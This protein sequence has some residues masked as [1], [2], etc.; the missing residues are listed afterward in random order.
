MKH[1]FYQDIEQTVLEAVQECF[2]QVS[3]RSPLLEIP[4]DDSLGDLSSSIALKLASAQ[5]SSPLSIAETIKEALLKKAREDKTLCIAKIVIVKPGFLNIY[6]TEQCLKETAFDLVQQ[7][8]YL[9]TITGHSERILLEYVSANPTGPLSIAHGRQAIIGDVLARVFALCEVPVKR[10]YYINDEGRQIDLLVQSFGERVKQA[11][12]ESYAIPEDGYQGEYL[13]PIA[14]RYV[15]EQSTQD[16]EIYCL[17]AMLG[18]IKDELSV[19]GVGFD[20]WTSQKKLRT[21]GLIAE[22]ISVLRSQG[23]IE[24]KEDATWFKSTLFGDDKDRVLI[25]KDGSYTYFA[26][27]IA[28][29]YM[30]IKQGYT[31]LINLW[32]PDHHGYI[33][34]MKASL[35]AL[36]FSPAALDILIIQLVTLKNKEKMSKRKG[37]IILLSDLIEDVGRDAAR[38]YYITRKNSSHLDFD[39]ELAKTFSFDN[40]LYYIQ[41]A[42][43]RIASIVRKAE[44]TIGPCSLER[45]S[46]T[47]LKEKEEIDVLR[48][49]CYFPVYLLMIM[50]SLEP[51]FIPEYLKKLAALFHKFYEKHTVISNDPELTRARIALVLMVKHVLGTGLNLLGINA[52]E[53]M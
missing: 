5:K 50:Q 33:P 22:V 12:G 37:N 41:Y 36:G 27:D 4:K 25:K 17:Q 11:R 24:E 51:F 19:A 48:F 40:P 1:F 46:L 39:I 53:K 44:E 52:P 49:M 45:A 47:R 16:H 21:D 13:V 38:F 8:E 20:V 34:R 31:R 6:L 29:H 43:A 15:S 35:Q 14:R 10:Q 18:L 2:P 3:V 42:H 26:A 28:F 32:G 9:K 30:K 23:H 7:P